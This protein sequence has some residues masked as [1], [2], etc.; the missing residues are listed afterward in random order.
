MNLRNILKRRLRKQR[1][2]NPR[3]MNPI[4]V[5]RRHLPS[6]EIMNEIASYLNIICRLKV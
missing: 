6:Q 5:S 1:S 2:S 3:E 4:R